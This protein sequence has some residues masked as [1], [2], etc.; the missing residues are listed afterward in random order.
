MAVLPVV[1]IRADLSTF[2]VPIPGG[3]L[4]LPPYVQLADEDGPLSIH[5]YER[6]TVLYELGDGVQR[7]VVTYRHL[8][9]SHADREEGVAP[10]LGEFKPP[11]FRPPNNGPK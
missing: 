2:T 4:H 5:T 8:R 10:E 1:F 6:Q 9:T 3:A 7:R 11:E